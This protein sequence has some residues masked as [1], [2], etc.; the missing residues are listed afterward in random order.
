[1]H[2]HS[3]CVCVCVCVCVLAP[4]AFN[5]LSPR[6]HALARSSAHIISPSPPSG[7]EVDQAIPFPTDEPAAPELLS[8]QWAQVRESDAHADDAVELEKRMRRMVMRM[9]RV[10]RSKRMRRRMRRM[11]M[12]R[13]MTMTMRMVRG[14]GGGGDTGKGRDRACCTC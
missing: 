7:L 4:S 13:R 1:M 14:G 2:E 8:R 10:S 3:T 11:V 5:I 12:R 9:S 6:C